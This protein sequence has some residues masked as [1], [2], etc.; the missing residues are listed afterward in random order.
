LSPGAPAF[1]FSPDG[2]RIYGVRRSEKN[3]WKTVA[4]DIVT[5][6]ATDMYTMELPPS[7]TVLGFAMHPGGTRFS[8][9][10]GTPRHDVWMLDGLNQRR[11][12]WAS[13]FAR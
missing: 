11:S 6:A 10:V 4:I 13:L 9:A 7:A 12:W 3:F 1:G 2:T 8:S 5:G